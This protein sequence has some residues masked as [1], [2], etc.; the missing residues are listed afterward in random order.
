LKKID[1]YFVLAAEEAFREGRRSSVW[2]ALARVELT[3]LQDYIL[4]RG[5]LDG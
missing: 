3:F 5:F 2:G 4:R 1:K